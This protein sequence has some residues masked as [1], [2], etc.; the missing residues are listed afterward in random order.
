MF[1]PRAVLAALERHRVNS[2]VIG[3]VARVLDGTDEVANG[4]DVCP[5]RRDENLDRLDAAL[6]ELEAQ[7][8][9]Q[10]VQAG[11]AVIPRSTRS[12]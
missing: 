9:A 7:P 10:A 8:V 4:L 12:D 11:E 5:Q 2:V 1:D 3:A 6:A